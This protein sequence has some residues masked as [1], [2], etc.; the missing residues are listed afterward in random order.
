MRS[1]L[2]ELR[3]GFLF[4]YLLMHM[5]LN[6]KKVHVFRHFL[7]TRSQKEATQPPVQE[8]CFI[9]HHPPL[10][11]RMIRLGFVNSSPH[12]NS[13]RPVRTP[14]RNG[15]VFYEVTTPCRTRSVLPVNLLADSPNEFILVE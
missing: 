13:L 5:W 11:F 14:H 1:A 6:Q 3:C 12:G 9:N 15:Y 8:Y 2:H 7:R 10:I 4:P